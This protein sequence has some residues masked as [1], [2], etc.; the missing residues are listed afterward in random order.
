MYF[1]YLRGKQFELDA[2]V[3]LQDS[4]FKN[5]IPIIEPVNKPRS[6]QYQKLTQSQKK[7][8]FLVNPFHPPGERMDADAIDDLIS[9]QIAESE[10]V[11]FGFIIDQ[12]YSAGDLDDF[13]TEYSDFSK[14]VVFR[15]NPLPPDQTAIRNLLKKVPV[16]YIIFDDHKVNTRV[17]SQYEFHPRRVLL[18]DGFQRQD[19]NADYPI[20]S[21][22]ESNYSSYKEDGWFGIGDYLTIGDYFKKGGGAVYVVALHVTTRVRG[23]LIVNHFISTVYST[24][25][26]L[27]AP[28]FA[29]ANRLLIESPRTVPLNTDGIE[30]YRNWDLTEHNPQLGAAKKASI[31]HHIELL[32]TLI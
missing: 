5:T 30:L 27:P 17:R 3:E 23:N 31:M 19:R 26:G 25:K 1:P 13:F 14:A 16:D 8:I 6:R 7:F 11:I 32:S 24:T 4:I 12:R 28:K 20:N 2:L 21:T 18:T 22:F 10:N 15:H 9:S 29:E